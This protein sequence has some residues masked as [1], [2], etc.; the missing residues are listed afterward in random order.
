MEY[1][2]MQPDKLVEAISNE[3]GRK[4]GGEWRLFHA[5]SHRRQAGE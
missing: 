3:V 1:E 2:D 4:A 5:T